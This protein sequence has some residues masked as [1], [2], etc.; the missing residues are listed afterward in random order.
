MLLIYTLWKHQKTFRFSDVF[1]GYRQARLDCIGL[2]D[3]AYTRKENKKRKEASQYK[4]PSSL[5]IQRRDNLLYQS[6]LNTR[7]SEVLETSEI[8]FKIY[9]EIN[10]HNYNLTV[11]NKPFY[12]K[13]LKLKGTK[14]QTN[15]VTKL[16]WFVQQN[17]K[18][19][20]CRK[21]TSLCHWVSI[22]TY[23]V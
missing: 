2:N 3:K 12:K 22:N 14:P 13:I 18:R 15:K 20:I 4:R 17:F 19:G 9:I 21:P 6:I 11:T 7:W 5:F 1:R 10:T 8:V 16:R 23:A